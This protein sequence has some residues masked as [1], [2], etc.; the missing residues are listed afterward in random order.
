MKYVKILGPLAVAAAALMAFAGS[1]SATEL[2]NL[3]GKVYGV[4]HETKS[5]RGE[6]K[7]HDRQH[8]GSRMQ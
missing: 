7:D 4:G 5:Y 8:R 3:E 1:A 6:Q 2:T